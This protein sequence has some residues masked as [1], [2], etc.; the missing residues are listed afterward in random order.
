M[1]N[2]ELQSVLDMHMLLQ[3]YV[4]PV[5]LKKQMQIP[6][7]TQVHIDHLLTLNISFGKAKIGNKDIFYYTESVQKEIIFVSMT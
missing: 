2:C 3:Q 5:F 1:F 4:V 7:K 6:Y